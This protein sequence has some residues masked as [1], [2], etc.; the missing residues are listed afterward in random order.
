MKYRTSFLPRSKFWGLKIS[1]K[2]DSVALGSLLSSFPEIS[3]ETKHTRL[4]V[5]VV[6]THEGM[7]YDVRNLGECPCW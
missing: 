1:K 4:F 7:R 2:N 5:N 3:L 6:R